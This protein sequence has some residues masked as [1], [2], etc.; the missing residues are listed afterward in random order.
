MPYKYDDETIFKFFNYQAETEDNNCRVMSLSN[1]IEIII[2][3]NI[4][5]EKI[6]YD[7]IEIK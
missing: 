1:F 3:K 5:T 6:I 4:I 7:F 2:D